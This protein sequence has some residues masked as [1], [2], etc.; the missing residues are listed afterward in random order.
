M[1]RLFENLVALEWAVKHGGVYAPLAEIFTEMIWNTRGV[2]GE[3][4]TVKHFGYVMGGWTE[5]G[6]RSG[7][8]R[9][10]FL[11]GLLE[12]IPVIWEYCPLGIK[13]CPLEAE[14]CPLESKYC[15]LG[16]K[17]CPLDFW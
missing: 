13:Y 5:T 12:G 3:M 6:R 16:V 10:V 14:Y 1:A 2:G 9:P 11:C 17:Y 7:D 8:Q 15:P 4:K